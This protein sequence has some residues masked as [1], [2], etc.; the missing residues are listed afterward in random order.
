M[1]L[2]TYLTYAILASS[3]S[4]IMEIS[5]NKVRIINT[6]RDVISAKIEPASLICSNQEMHIAPQS[7]QSIDI[8]ECCVQ[9]IR[10]Q[11]L[12]GPIRGQ[13]TAR[14]FGNLCKDI[15]IIIR[16]NSDNTLDF[17]D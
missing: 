7:E 2:N 10:I 8:G 9:T 13:T 4:M 16:R 15:K 11:G 17:V 1:K 3:I 5:A 14:A 12:T 6:T